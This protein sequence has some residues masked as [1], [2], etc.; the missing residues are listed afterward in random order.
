MV[1]VWPVWQSVDWRPA[2]LARLRESDH[3]HEWSDIVV[4]ADEAAEEARY[5]LV[6]PPAAIC[7]K[8]FLRHW[9][10]RDSAPETEMARRGFASLAELGG[11][12]RRFFAYDVQRGRGLARTGAR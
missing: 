8:L 2:A 6:V 9:H 3:W 5:R 1:R 11:T 4:S 7:G 10:Q 12:V